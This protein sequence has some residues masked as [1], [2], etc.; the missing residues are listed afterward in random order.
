MSFLYSIKDP[1]PLILI[2]GISGVGKTS[3]INC[4]LAD[5]PN[6]FSQP[7]SYTSRV[8]RSDNERY[9]FK[10]KKEITEMY[11]TGQLYN[12]DLVYNEVYAISKLSV[13]KIIMSGKIPVKELHPDN[14][15]KFNGINTITVVIE[16]T[17]NNTNLP[18]KNREDRPVNERWRDEG[19]IDI[20][21]NISGL[22]I[23]DATEYFIK[24]I[25]A[26]RKHVREYP[27]PN[28]IDKTNKAG[29]S[30]LAQEFNDEKRITT[31][32]FHDISVPFWIYFLS[33]IGAVNNLLEIGVGNGWLF[34]NIPS[35]SKNIYGLDISEN[36]NADYVDYKIVSTTRN[37]PVTSSKF[38]AVVASL[39]DPFLYPETILEVSRVLKSGGCFAFTHPS[40]VWG[41]N[42]KQR[43]N[44]S[45]TT[46]RTQDNERVEVFSFCGGL[47]GLSEIITL[48]GLQVIFSSEYYLPVDYKY[49][50]S[51][52]ILDSNE[53]YGENSSDLPIIIGSILRKK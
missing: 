13:K 26:F 21:I 3:I 47:Q 19:L 17:H 48:S 25:F 14:F 20:K 31:K 43:R 44:K 39:A 4:L 51:K 45:T 9:I 35:P 38:D 16:N 28:K 36:M 32:N 30:K 8:K 37:I 46:F 33:Y 42:L 27:H 2:G 53:S 12:L 34:S 52:A 41:R 24:R 40:L 5:Y 6:L 7:K 1:T 10:E 18:H 29:Y 22:N 23:K 11:D 50:V 15:C 49:N